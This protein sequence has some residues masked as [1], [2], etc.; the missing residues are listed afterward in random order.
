M[1]RVWLG[2]LTTIAF[3]AL[4]DLLV[5][6]NSW[7][8][9]VLDSSGLGILI[10]MA[11]GAF[12]ARRNFLIPALAMTVTFWSITVYVA[13]Q[14]AS[15]VE[16]TSWFQVAFNNVA[17]LATYLIAASIGAVVGMRLASIRQASHSTIR[18]Q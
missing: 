11:V 4:F 10:M 8:G 17:G 9:N 12:V 15:T 6:S 7:L 3:G 18:T 5:P 13:F 2:I 14:I 1:K 16:S